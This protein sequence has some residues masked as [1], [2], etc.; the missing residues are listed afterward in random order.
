MADQVII[1]V[2]NV[3]QAPYLKNIISDVSVDK[4]APDQIIDLKSVFM[5]DDASDILTYKITSNSN[6]AIVSPQISG[7]NLILSFSPEHTGLATIEIVAES[8]GKTVSTRFTVEVKIPTGMD[9]ASAKQ[10]ITIW[11]NPT[12]GKIR[13][14]I[15]Q[16]T[17]SGTE[18]IVT[19]L[20]GKTI[21]KQ[22]I[23]GN[24]GWID[25]AGYS[26]GLYLFKTNLDSS[27]VQK[28]ILK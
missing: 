11:P 1:T 8:S 27:A 2:K 18:L 7:T 23:Y 25:L 22:I 21:I 3:D 26:P 9:A 20:I 19:N 12:D 13:I 17:P 10:K 16:I 4:R 5:D 6:S 24:E 15:D 14:V 28:V